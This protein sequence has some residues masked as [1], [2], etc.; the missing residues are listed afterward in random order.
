M[1]YR[2]LLF[3][4]KDNIHVRVFMITANTTLFALLLA[5]LTPYAGHNPSWFFVVIYLSVFGTGMLFLWRW[6]RKQYPL[7]RIFI[8]ALLGY[9]ASVIARGL[10]MFLWH[11]GGMDA[12]IESFVRHGQIRLDV[13]LVILVFAPGWVHGAVVA[14]DLPPKRTEAG[15]KSSQSGSA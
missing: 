6:L 14:L 12:L 15:E 2:S 9:I 3:G 5:V 7:V 11:G 10:H 13:F 1:L 4:K 8:G